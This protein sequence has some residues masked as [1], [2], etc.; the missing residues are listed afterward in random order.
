MGEA[1]LPGALHVQVGHG[2]RLE[3][4]LGEVRDDL[5]VHRGVRVAVDGQRQQQLVRDARHLCEEEN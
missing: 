3:A 5:D 4:D 1:D 2:L